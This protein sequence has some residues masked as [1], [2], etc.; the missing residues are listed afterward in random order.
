[1]SS[2][3]PCM[4]QKGGSMTLDFLPLSNCLAWIYVCHPDRLFS[5]CHD[6]AL[7]PGIQV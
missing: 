5:F 2:D 7:G 6:I 3:I 1:M 4:N